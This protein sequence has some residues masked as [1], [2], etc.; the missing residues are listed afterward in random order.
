MVE[1][2]TIFMVLL[3]VLPIC[4]AIVIGINIINP[5]ITEITEVIEVDPI[6]IEHNVN[7]KDTS[8]VN[9][10]IN[11]DKIEWN[12]TNLEAN[13]TY[14]QILT[15]KNVGEYNITLDYE[16]MT[17]GLTPESIYDFSW[18]YDNNIIHSDES[19]DITLS[20][21]PLTEE[22]SHF[23]FDMIIKGEVI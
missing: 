9:F 10:T 3:I 4:G 14:Q 22:Y 23:G 21:T 15:V 1:G 8:F 20:L 13:V 19:L 16:L 5:Q 7:V 11:P 18:D 17:K 12:W 2:E 6:T